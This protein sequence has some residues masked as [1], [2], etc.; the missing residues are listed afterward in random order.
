MESGDLLGVVIG[1]SGL[2][3]GYHLWRAHITRNEI[4]R[5]RGAFD[6]SPLPKF[7]KSSDHKVIAVNA[8][9]EEVFGVTNEQVKAMSLA[10]ERDLWSSSPHAE[11]EETDNLALATDEPIHTVAILVPPY[12]EKSRLL[13]PYTPQEYYITKRRFRYGSILTT[14]TYGIIGTV[15]SIEIIMQYIDRVRARH[16]ELQMKS[17]ILSSIAELRSIV[18]SGFE[19]STAEMSSLKER[20]Q[21]TETDLQLLIT[22]VAPDMERTQRGGFKDFEG[23][24]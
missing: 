13:H 11:F 16:E 4:I 12:P 2:L 10:Q 23:L 15:F 5:F 19:K 20:M 7:L 22:K 8:A 24:T 14:P 17:P 9:F 18:E 6:F 3:V 21:N 1:L